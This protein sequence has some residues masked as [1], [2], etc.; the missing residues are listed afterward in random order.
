MFRLRITFTEK[1]ILNDFLF[2]KLQ[3]HGKVTKGENP[4]GLL[5]LLRCYFKL[6]IAE[7]ILQCNN[8][9]KVHTYKNNHAQSSCNKVKP[10]QEISQC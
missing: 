6:L 1:L 8:H 2:R 9:L 4:K 5:V 3:L 7:N 10:Q